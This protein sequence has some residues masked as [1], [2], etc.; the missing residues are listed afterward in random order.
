MGFSSDLPNMI[1]RELM[2]RQFLFWFLMVIPTLITGCVDTNLMQGI[3]KDN[4]S[5]ITT[6][7]FDIYHNDDPKLGHSAKLVKVGLSSRTKK[8]IGDG[9]N[10]SSTKKQANNTKTRLKRTLRRE[11]GF[12]TSV[13]SE[14]L[15]QLSKDHSHI[16]VIDSGDPSALLSLEIYY[17]TYPDYMIAV[18][19][20]RVFIEGKKAYERTTR[21]GKWN[22]ETI[23]ANYTDNIRT[24]IRAVL[25]R[26]WND[27]T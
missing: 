7:K 4:R 20:S 12:V 6:L 18:V 21:S 2:I 19:K 9:G 10:L 26:I 22:S 24:F 1:G 27:I 11:S 13:I 17:I 8:A 16:S 3:S 5:K 25:T 14:T 15:L 23:D